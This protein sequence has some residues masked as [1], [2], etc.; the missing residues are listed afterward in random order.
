[1]AVLIYLVECVHL[2]HLLRT[3]HHCVHPNGREGPTCLPTPTIP[4]C[5]LSNCLYRTAQIFDGENIDEFDEFP[6]IRQYF[7]YQIF[8]LV[9]YSMLMIGI[10][11]FFTR[12]N[13]PN[14]DSS[15]FSTVKILRHMVHYTCDIIGM[16][17]NYLK[18]S[19]EY[20]MAELSMKH[21]L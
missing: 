11:Q 13:F 14:R 15:K 21:W 10:R 4:T 7:P 5:H 17:K 8:H 6:A 20:C 19:R 9:S 18:T 12:Q 2:C 3:Q 16:V 1:M